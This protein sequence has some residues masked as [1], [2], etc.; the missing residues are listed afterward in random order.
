MRKTKPCTLNSPQRVSVEMDSAG[1]FT[2]VLAPVAVR[3]GFHT[4]GIWYHK[5]LL[6]VNITITEIVG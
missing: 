3:L 1:G 6:E 2:G 5:M 4:S